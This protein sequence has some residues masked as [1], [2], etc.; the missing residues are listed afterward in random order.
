MLGKV[1]SRQDNIAIDCFR[2]SGTAR[3]ISLAD[4]LLAITDNELSKTFEL[5]RTHNTLSKFMIAVEAVQSLP[6]A[7]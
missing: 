7:L 4:L 3:T 6:K 5:Q 1:P 2:F